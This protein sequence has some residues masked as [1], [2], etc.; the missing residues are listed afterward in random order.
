MGAPFRVNVAS[1]EPDDLRG[2]SLI[3]PR[4]RDS[5]RIQLAFSVDLELAW[6]K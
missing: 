5:V 3:R 1:A 2:V 6:S 4:G